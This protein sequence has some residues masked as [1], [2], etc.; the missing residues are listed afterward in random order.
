MDTTIY[1]IRHCQT[2]GQEPDAVLTAEGERQAEKLADFLSDAPITRIVSSPF[3]RAIQ[4]I[5]PL[6]HRLRLRIETDPRLQERVLSDSSLSNWRENLRQTFE[7][8]DLRFPGG[9]SS[10]EAMQRASAV[11]HDVL[12]NPTGV[13]AIVSH[14]NLSTLLLKQFDATIGFSTWER[15]TTPD[16]FALHL[17]EA[18]TRITRLWQVDGR[19]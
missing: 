17:G 19:H 12:R 18:G 4:S 10:R 6:A 14:G 9:E 5:E 11:V 1:L 8:L 3:V 16:V 2:T 13:V 7:Q 15:M